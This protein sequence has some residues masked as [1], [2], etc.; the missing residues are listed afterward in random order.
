[1]ST[2]VS[3]PI[4]SV[5]VLSCVVSSLLDTRALAPPDPEPQTPTHEKHDTRPVTAVGFASINAGI[6]TE[7]EKRVLYAL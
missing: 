4:A 3:V 6:R 1:M 2:I 7:L 5:L